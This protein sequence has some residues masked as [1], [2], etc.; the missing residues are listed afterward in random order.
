MSEVEDLLIEF[1]L[2]L[3]ISFDGFRSILLDPNDHAGDFVSLEGKGHAVA[4]YSLVDGL[5]I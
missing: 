3:V 4:F 1:V 5:Q 2:E